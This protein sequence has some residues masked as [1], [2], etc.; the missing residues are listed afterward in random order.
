MK[1]AAIVY[2]AICAAIITGIIIT[3]SAWPLLALICLPEVKTNSKDNDN[4]KQD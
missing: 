1:Y 4:D 3:K 2:S